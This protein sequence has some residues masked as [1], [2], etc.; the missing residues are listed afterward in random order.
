LNI[1][2]RVKQVMQLFVEPHFQYKQFPKGKPIL[3]SMEKL[4]YTMQKQ[5]K[6]NPWF[7]EMFIPSTLT[8]KTPLF[9]QNRCAEPLKMS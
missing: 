1:K 2:F 4:M 8:E 9:Q 6:Q 7:Q 5:K 3:S